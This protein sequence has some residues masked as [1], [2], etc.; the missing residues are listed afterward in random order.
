MI[1]ELRLIGKEVERFDSVLEPVANVNCHDGFGV[2][3][4]FIVD[5]SGRFELLK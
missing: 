1:A 5:E 3:R 4:L 2:T